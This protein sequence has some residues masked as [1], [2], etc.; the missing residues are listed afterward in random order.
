M[1]ITSPATAESATV[2]GTAHGAQVAPNDPE[3]FGRGGQTEPESHDAGHSSGSSL[4]PYEREFEIPVERFK[5]A[6][7]VRPPKREMSDAQR[8][9]VESMRAAR[10]AKAGEQA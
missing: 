1:T 9:V 7:A 8:A 6:Q 2:N 4:N 3:A 10:E 5:I